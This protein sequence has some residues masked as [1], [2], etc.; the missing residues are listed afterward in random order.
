MVINSYLRF[1]TRILDFEGLTKR[2]DFWSAFFVSWII[3]VLLKIFLGDGIPDLYCWVS[4]IPNVSIAMRRV[5][6]SGK[7][8]KWIFI[9]LIPIIG[10]IWFFI[11]LIQPSKRD[12]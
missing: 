6:D 5:R 4:L 8:R 7:S 10:Q 2:G 9:N 3:F 12:S 1:W 11:F